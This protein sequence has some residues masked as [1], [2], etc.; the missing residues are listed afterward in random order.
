MTKRISLVLVSLLLGIPLLSQ[1]AAVTKYPWLQPLRQL[2][3]LPHLLFISALLLLFGRTLLP[4]REPL[5]AVIARSVHGPLAPAVARYTR[6]VTQ[7]WTG[8]FALLLVE[9]GLLA[10]L[11]P[12]Q[13][14]TLV[15]GLL[16]FILIALLFVTEFFWR[17]RCLPEIEHIGFWSYLQV[18]RKFDF[19]KVSA[20]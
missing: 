3:F 2:Y 18:L 7:F 6:R 13:I 19:R 11:A 8:L 4:G 17:R 12:L 14:G 1:L 20:P 16:N 5:V 10:W 15:V 9:I